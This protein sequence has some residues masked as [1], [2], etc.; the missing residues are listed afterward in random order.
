MGSFLNAVDLKF[1]K[2]RFFVASA[3]G[4]TRDAGQYKP[5][6][7]L[8]PMEWISGISDKKLSDLWSAT[9]FNDKSLKKEISY[10]D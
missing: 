10:G 8:E 9:K 3:I 2:N 4:H 6:G 5:M 1:Q 7:V